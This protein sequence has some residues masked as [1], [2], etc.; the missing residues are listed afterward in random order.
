MLVV[1]AGIHKLLVRISNIADPDQTSSCVCLGLFAKQIVFKIVY[2]GLAV[3][4]DC[5]VYRLSQ[6][7]RIL[8]S[9]DSEEHVQPLFRLRTSRRCR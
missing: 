3:I 5:S 6:Q 7:L 2:S 9:V 1:M 4:C 8:T